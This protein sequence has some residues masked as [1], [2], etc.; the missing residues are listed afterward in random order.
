MRH[1][2]PCGGVIPS[3]PFS[4][5]VSGEANGAGPKKAALRMELNVPCGLRQF[6]HILLTFG[7]WFLY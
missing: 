5:I 4:A 3:Q 7:P 1:I 2:G 6:E